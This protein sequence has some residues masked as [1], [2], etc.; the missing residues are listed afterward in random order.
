M[1]YASGVPVA[2]SLATRQFSAAT[3]DALFASESA[4]GDM[5]WALTDHLGTVRV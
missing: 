4:T 2:G 1:T 5:F 3:Y